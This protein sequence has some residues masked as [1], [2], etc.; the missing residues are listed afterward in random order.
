MNGTLN[1]NIQTILSFAIYLLC[2]LFL[3][4]HQHTLAQ[5]GSRGRGLAMQ[6]QLLGAAYVAQDDEVSARAA[7]QRALERS[8]KTRMS[9]YRYSPRIADVWTKAGGQIDPGE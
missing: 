5:A 6:G 8:S 1:I 7:F 3:M 4:I 9:R 2:A